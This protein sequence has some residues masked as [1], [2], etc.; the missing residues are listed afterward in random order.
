MPYV[1]EATCL[2]RRSYLTIMHL[3]AIGLEVIILWRIL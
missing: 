1:T 3:I 2:A